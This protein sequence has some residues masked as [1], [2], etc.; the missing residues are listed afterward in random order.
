VIDDYF[1][2]KDGKLEY[3]AYD[4][5]FIADT[6]APLGGYIERS[7]IRREFCSDFTGGINFYDIINEDWWE[8]C[9]FIEKGIVIKIECVSKGDKK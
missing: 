6:N 7:N 2:T 5:E 1:L 8:Y 3:E 9:A 4:K